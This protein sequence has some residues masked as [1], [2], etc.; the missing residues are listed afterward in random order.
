MDIV[1]LLFT[2]TTKKTRD[3]HYQS[4]LRGY[5]DELTSTLRAL[6]CDPEEVV[7]WSVFQDQLKSHGR[8]GIGMALVTTPLFL[9]DSSEVPANIDEL[10]ENGNSNLVDIFSSVNTKKLDEVKERISD[11]LFDSIQ[12]GYL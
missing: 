10:M 5:F 12:L 11:G 8:F 6:G 9:A 3:V 7:S 1:Y 2:C 4:L